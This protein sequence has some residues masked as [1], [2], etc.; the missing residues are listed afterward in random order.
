MNSRWSQGPSR[1]TCL[2]LDELRPTSRELLSPKVFAY[3]LQLKTQV[4]LS[5]ITESKVCC[6]E[7][8]LSIAPVTEAILSKPKLFN[9]PNHG[10]ELSKSS[11]SDSMYSTAFYSP[12]S[13]LR[14]LCSGQFYTPHS[15]EDS[16]AEGALFDLGVETIRLP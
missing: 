10:A 12:D 5:A 6:P 16:V 15:R 9:P 14:K 8:D 11:I 3:F 13:L 1:N 2:A 4:S 7:S